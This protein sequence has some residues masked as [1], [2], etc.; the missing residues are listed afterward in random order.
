MDIYYED[1]EL[2]QDRVTGYLN[3]I[4]T[5]LD[6]YKFDSDFLKNI[7]TKLDSLQGNI[8]DELDAIERSGTGRSVSKIK[9]PIKRRGL[10]SFLRKL[11]RGQTWLI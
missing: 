11:W 5:S 9:I 8:K 4:E 2:Y 3:K 6:Y 1:L 10:F 7:S